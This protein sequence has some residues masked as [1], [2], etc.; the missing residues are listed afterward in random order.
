ML[1]VSGNWAVYSSRYRMELAHTIRRSLIGIFFVFAS[2]LLY[3]GVAIPLITPGGYRESLADWLFPPGLVVLSLILCGCIVRLLR[4]ST[5][6][7]PQ[8]NAISFAVVVGIAFLGA[9]LISL[10]IWRQHWLAIFWSGRT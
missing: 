3:F 10:L 2:I 7:R 8:A 5:P 9:V 6:T 1:V 4:G